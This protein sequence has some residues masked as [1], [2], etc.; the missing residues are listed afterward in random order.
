M[1]VINIC[2]S[3]WANF[4]YD[5]SMALRSVGIDCVA[6]KLSSHKFKYSNEAKKIPIS[7]MQRLIDKADLVQ[8]FF[9][10]DIFI[11]MCKGKRVIVYHAGTQYRNN[12]DYYNE[13][14][15]HIVEKTVIALGEF[16]GLGAK[17]EVYMVGAINTN[18]YNHFREPKRPYKIGHFPSN[19]EIKGTEKIIEMIKKLSAHGLFKWSVKPV[20]AKEQLKRMLDSDIYIELFKPELKGKKYG[21]WGITCLEAAAMGKVVVTQNLSDKVYKA[22]Y[23]EHPLVLCEN[24]KDFIDKVNSLLVMDEKELRYLQ[25]KTRSWVKLKHGYK[26]TGEYWLKNIA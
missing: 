11:P 18:N 19:A 6:Y 2:Q 23:G 10:E 3:D 20:L 13:K 17:N 12:P 26:A 7:D 25:E 15:N 14:F 4:A 5:N 16:A 21:S 8:I 1:K 24:E 9:S 22:N